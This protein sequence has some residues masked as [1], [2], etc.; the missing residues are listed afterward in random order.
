[1][2][3]NDQFEYGRIPLKPLPLTNKEQ[4]QVNE[5]IIDYKKHSDGTDPEYHIYIADSDDPTKLI[6]ITNLIIKEILPNAKINANQFQ[7]KIDGIQDPT[8]LSKIIG[9]IYKHFVLP[10]DFNYNEDI[11]KVLSE[12]NTTK[13]ALLV[14]TDG[15]VILPITKASNVFDDTGESIQ[16][17]LDNMTRVCISTAYIYATE[18]NQTS[19]EFSYPFE[20][21]NEFIEI[22]IGTTYIDSTRYMITPN[23]DANGNYTT[24]TLTFI[25]GVGENDTGDSI[26]INRRIDFIF[27]YNALNK[28]TGGCKVMN[29]RAIADSTIPACKLEFTSDSYIYNN[30]NCIATSAAVYNLFK[31]IIN[32]GINENI[33]YLMDLNDSANVINIDLNNYNINEITFP[34][35]FNLILTSNKRNAM[36]N[37]FIQFKKGTSV[38]KTYNLYNLLDNSL[39]ELSG[40]KVYTIYIPS[41]N[42]KAYIL[43]PFN[44]LKSSRYV[45]L[46]E[47]QETEIS[48]ENLDCGYD[49]LIH[50]YRNGVR[51]FEDIDYSNDT[52]SKKITLFVRTEENERII[53][54]TLSA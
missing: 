17:R 37:L 4:A 25:P 3:A 28:G 19:F 1:M 10:N 24:G 32:D 47:D 31:K 46:C 44:N 42:N 50:V 41:D 21:Y 30:S 52:I 27:M 39:Y 26:E 38:Y 8:D 23:R 2:S 5:L 22:R 40:G 43:T 14:Q 7:I 51:L 48:Y 53:F 11:D 54:E 49:D 6:D 33:Q 20:N 12:S 45:H 16:S 29:G 34:F 13:S 35:V 9:Y 15:T 18:D 36:G